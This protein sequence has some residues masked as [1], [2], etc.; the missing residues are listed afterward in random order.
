MIIVMF[1]SVAWI[2]VIH[3]AANVPM[4]LVKTYGVFL[5]EMM[6]ITINRKAHG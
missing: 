2:K 4:F 3:I 5:T 1:Q 6:N